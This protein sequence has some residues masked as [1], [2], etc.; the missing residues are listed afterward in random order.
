VILVTTALIVLISLLLRQPLWAFG[1]VLV[2][3]VSGMAWSLLVTRNVCK[4]FPEAR[5]AMQDGDYEMYRYW[6]S[7]YFRERLNSPKS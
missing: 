5:Q 1:A 3:F 4:R 6:R 2:T 7:K